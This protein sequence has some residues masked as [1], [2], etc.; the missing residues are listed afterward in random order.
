[1][2][3]ATTNV[4]AS[5][6]INSGLAHHSRPNVTRTS[7]KSIPPLEREESSDH[8]VSRQVSFLTSQAMGRSTPVTGPDRDAKN[9]IDDFRTKR[10]D[11]TR[12]KPEKFKR[13][14]LG[15]NGLLKAYSGRQVF[16]GA[17]TD[18]LN[19]V[20]EEYDTFCD[21]CGLS[22]HEKATTLPLLLRGNAITVYSTQFK[23]SAEGTR[24]NLTYDQVVQ[25]FKNH[26]MSNEQKHRIL[27]DWETIR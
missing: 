10:N 8:V 5:N 4:N 24:P 14:N 15:V 26:Y 12:E 17:I 27:M 3:N 9:V 19:A 7:P 25:A 23:S 11:A 1:M 2:L 6:S 20:L 18:D 21:L 16:S 13:T 22:D